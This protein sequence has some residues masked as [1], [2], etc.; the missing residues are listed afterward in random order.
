VY[1]TRDEAGKLYWREIVEIARQRGTGWCDYTGTHP[2]TKVREPKSLYVE[3]VGDLIVGC[4][5]YRA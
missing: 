2:K 1:D 3:R 4:G 5:I